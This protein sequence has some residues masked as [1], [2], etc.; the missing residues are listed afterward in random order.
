MEGRQKMQLMSGVNLRCRFL[1][2]GNYQ[3]VLNTLQ[4]ELVSNR[5]NSVLV[6]S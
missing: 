3:K 5:A 4:S 6:Y 1:S 2:V